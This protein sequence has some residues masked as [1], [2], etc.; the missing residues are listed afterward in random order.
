M[1]ERGWVWV[2]LI[3]ICKEMIIKSKEGRRKG[4]GE[5][6]GGEGEKGGRKGRERRGEEGE[7]LCEL[8]PTVMENDM[9]NEPVK[10][11]EKE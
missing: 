8:K 5:M 7:E 4:R 6:E 9:D 1:Q 11:V 10:E 2:D 3:L